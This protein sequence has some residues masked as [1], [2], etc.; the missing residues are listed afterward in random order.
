MDVNAIRADF[1]AL[2]E[3]A[4]GPS[5]QGRELVYLDNAATTQR[6]RQV[7]DTLAAV[8]TSYNANVHR[9][10]HA[11]ARGASELYEQARESVARFINAR[12]S[13]EIVFT[14]NATEALNLVAV[15]LARAG[16]GSLRLQPGDEII[17]TLMEHHSNLVPWQALCAEAGLVLRIVGITR[18]DTLDMGNLARL[19][20]PRTRLVCCTHVSNVLGTINP[21]E[22]IAGTVHAA[23]AMLLVDGAQSTPSMPVDVQALGCDF[24][25]FSGHKMLA[26]FGVGVL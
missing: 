7:L 2:Q 13:R 19:L 20:G 4:D 14:R 9:S 10:S 16:S 6:P 3:S 22:E 12:A 17:V 24:F 5:A 11:L 21:I 23:G 1:P 26:P 8:Y 25:A 15:S 18:G